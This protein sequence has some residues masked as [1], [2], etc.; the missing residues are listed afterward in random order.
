MLKDVQLDTPA[1]IYNIQE[2]KMPL[3]H[4]GPEHKKKVSGNCN[5]ITVIACVDA[6][7]QVI[8]PFVIFDAMPL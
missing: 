7:G 2:T 5:Q 6:I 3:D 1:Q 8:P 4:R